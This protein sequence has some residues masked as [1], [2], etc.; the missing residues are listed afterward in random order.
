MPADV[1]DYVRDRVAARLE[2][3]AGKVLSVLVRFDDPNGHRGGVDC[4][5]QMDALLPGM[6]PIVVH[7]RTEDLRSAVDLALDSLETAV[8]RHLERRVDGPRERGRKL[9]RNRKLLT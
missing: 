9:I 3:F 2:K 5:C 7:E 1:R 4:M 6:P 8:Q